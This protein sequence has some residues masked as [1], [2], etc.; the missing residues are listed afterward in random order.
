MASPQAAPAGVFLSQADCQR[1]WQLLGAAAMLNKKHADGLAGPVCLSYH[2]GQ[3]ELSVG[4]RLVGDFEGNGLLDMG[5]AL[6]MHCL[7]TI[8]MDTTGIFP[9]GCEEFYYGPAVPYDFDWDRM[10]EPDE[11]TRQLLGKPDQGTLRMA[12]G[13]SWTRT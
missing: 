3:G 2:A 5:P 6:R 13:P 11:A 7:G 9:S 12:C 1:Q 10:P 8:D 4:R